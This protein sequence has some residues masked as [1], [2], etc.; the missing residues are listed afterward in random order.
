[1]LSEAPDI[2]SPPSRL[3]V[4]D[5]DGSRHEARAIWHL[6]SAEIA[7]LVGPETLLRVIE[8]R[9]W[10]AREAR[11]IGEPA[12]AIGEVA[13]RLCTIG[14]PVDRIGVSINTLH[15]E[16]DVIARIWVRGESY[17]EHF[18]R[19]GQGRSQGYHRSPFKVAYETGEVV[20]LW[21]PAT[22]DTRFEIV[23]DLKAQGFVHSCTISACP[24]SS[25]P[26]GAAPRPL[27]RA[28]PKGSARAISRS[29][30]R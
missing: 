18:F 8:T 10:V 7:A 16:H 26:A 2:D 21:L 15:T 11:A 5:P 29:C 17:R 13:E 23:P 3:T 30:A 14:V 27:R 6:P 1:M 28:R 19:H 22:P 4:A 24:S 9:D 20:E 12:N 25:R